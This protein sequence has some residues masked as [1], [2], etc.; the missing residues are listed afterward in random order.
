MSLAEELDSNCLNTNHVN[1]A[2]PNHDVEEIAHFIRS[3][4]NF[5]CFVLVDP[6]EN[7]EFGRHIS[8]AIVQ[9][10]HIRELTIHHGSCAIRDVVAWIGSRN[11]LVNMTS[12]ESVLVVA[13]A[14]HDMS[15]LDCS[16]LF[17]LLLT[18]TSLQSFEIRLEG[19]DG[20]SDDAM[21]AL[22]SYLGAAS[23]REFEFRTR[24]LSEAAFTTLCD[25]VVLSTVRQFTLWQDVLQKFNPET[26]A[27]SLAW[28]I[29]ESS[30]EK[31]LIEGGLSDTRSARLISAL[32]LTAPVRN[33]DFAFIHIFGYEAVHLRINRKWKPLVVSANTPL[34]LW[35]H[36]LEKSHASP[37]TSHDSADVVFY[38]LRQKPDLVPAP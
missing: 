23:L 19:R 1:R 35:P 32:K 28:M 14:E 25:G 13:D 21:S 29:V 5:V 8:D 34:A 15:V 20:C 9:N 17:P 36:I 31:V 6:P 18:S 12:L 11:T 37:E 16:A 4:E 24:R 10:D 22:S 33:M 26:A 30:L 3:S 27:E 38:F 2:F 7:E